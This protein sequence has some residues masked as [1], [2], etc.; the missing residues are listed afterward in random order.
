MIPIRCL[1]S[2]P[3]SQSKKY[4]PYTEGDDKTLRYRLYLTSEIRVGNV[5]Y[6]AKKYDAALETF[7]SVLKKADQIKFPVQHDEAFG[8][9]DSGA[10]RP[11]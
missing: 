1:K 7:E 9:N 11:S 4:F 6:D 2:M 8:R 5:E 10:C 3:T